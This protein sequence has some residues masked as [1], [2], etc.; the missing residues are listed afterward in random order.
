MFIFI[1][2]AVA[3]YY[4]AMFVF[5]VGEIFTTLGKQPYITRRIPAT[6]RGRVSSISGIF[7]SGFQMISQ[8]MVGRLADVWQLSMVWTF[9]V[10]VGIGSVALH[11]LLRKTDHKTYP[12]LYTDEAEAKTV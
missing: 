10:G 11:F 6:H 8:L 5:T 4:V 1:G 2:E 12:L 3:L 9:I 7:I